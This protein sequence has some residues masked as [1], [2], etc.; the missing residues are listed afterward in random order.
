MPKAVLTGVLL[1]E[2]VFMLMELLILSEDREGGEGLRL[3]SC[4][5][6]CRYCRHARWML[7]RQQST[8]LVSAST[9]RIYA[10]NH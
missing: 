6:R 1:S 8:Q 7:G 4:S 9:G 3:P 2:K 5:W 10:K